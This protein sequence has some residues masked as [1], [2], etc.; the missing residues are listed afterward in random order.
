MSLPCHDLGELYPFQS[1]YLTLDHGVRLHYLDE[2]EGPVVVL[3]HGN[4]TWSFYYRELIKTLRGQYRVIVPDHV[5]C[6]FSDK[7]QSYA[8]TLSQHIANLGQLLTSL[9][10]KDI[11][12]GVHDW[13]G[14]IGF[15][16]AVDHPEMVKKFVVF[17]TA[18]FA[19]P[20]PISIRICRWPVI[21]EFIV[22]GVNGFALPATRMAFA[23]PKRISSEVK[24]GYLLPYDSYANRIAVHQFVKDIPL[25]KG[26]VSYATIKHT[27][28]SLSIFRDH[29][30][31]IC[32]GAHDFCFN[33]W[34]FEQWKRR[35]PKAE[36]HY[37]AEAGHYVVEEA[38]EEIRPLMMG[39]LEEGS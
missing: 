22:R 23:H 7:P 30:M 36:T 20:C 1:H 21:G 10:V 11:S 37:F 19:G 39:F 26:A 8:Y 25:S 9:K 6:G 12:L 16:W 32:W 4:P 38:I 15:G 3:L 5:G 33:D 13:G 17:N 29:P 2:G 18:A 24:R 28:D 35:F 14:A 31:L 34:Y 27:E